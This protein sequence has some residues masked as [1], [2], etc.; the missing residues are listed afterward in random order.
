MQAVETSPETKY[1]LMGFKA[2]PFASIFDSRRPASE[3]RAA[4]RTLKEHFH[5]N[6]PSV[7][8]IYI[9]GR[10]CSLSFFSKASRHCKTSHE[11]IE[12]TLIP[13]IRSSVSGNCRKEG[14]LCAKRAVT[15]PLQ[16]VDANTHSRAGRHH[17]TR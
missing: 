10:M 12:L 1:G 7:L 11:E 4:P 15:Q 9:R 17:N 3:G 5:I 8:L 13:L 16:P 2:T 6:A 14:R